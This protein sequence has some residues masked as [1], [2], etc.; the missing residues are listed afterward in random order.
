MN[1]PIVQMEQPGRTYPDYIPPMML[2]SVLIACTHFPPLNR[3]GARR[4]YYLAK[5]LRE[6][7]HKVS[8][9]TTAEEADAGWLPDME[10]IE[11]MRCPRTYLQRD[12]HWWQK[13]IARLHESLK[14]SFLH[15]PVRV[16]ADLLLPEEHASRWD[17]QPDE[18]EE[19]L[20]KAD[21]V[22]ATVPGWGPARMAFQLASAWDATFLLD[23]RDPGAI[24][25]PEVHMDIVSGH[26]TGISG[27][28][29]RAVFKARERRLGR[30]TYAIT[31]VSQAFLQNAQLITHNRR[32]AAF[33][34]GFDPAIRFGPPIRNDKFT[35]VYTGRLYS[36][37]DWGIVLDALEQLA[38][39]V[40]NLGRYFR[41]K[42]VGAVSN[43]PDL[44]DRIQKAS[45]QFD[46]LE[47][48][49]RLS[50]EESVRMQHGADALLHLT[51]RGR[52]GYLPVKFLEYIGSGRP[53]VLIS[54]E[55][56][57]MEAILAET[58]TGQLVRDAGSL[59][60]LL[61]KR[62]AA[63]RQGEQWNIAVDKDALERYIY[64]DCLLPWV[65]QI[66]IWHRERLR[67]QKR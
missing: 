35:L 43:D 14:G 23:Y 42:M 60:K 6:A 46:F 3:T 56:D 58:N 19:R 28:L 39:S 62:L 51:Y 24:A 17:V 13:V 52:K 61:R 40:Q 67:E 29:R 47:I 36:E 32:G 12:L 8:I 44:L 1:I 65:D 10:G 21:V 41:L 53:I 54:Q 48:T 4:P 33:H 26:G 63:W 25:I 27:M 11:V 38:S 66:E 55:Q 20:G 9:L 15:G 57:V 64:P 37:Q 7:G 22:L 16:M 18:V 34:G 5:A 2:P 59:A 30:S 45:M 49:P 31:A 50:R